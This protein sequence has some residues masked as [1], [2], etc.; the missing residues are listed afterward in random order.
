MF[1]RSCHAVKMFSPAANAW[2]R[3]APVAAARADT[4]FAA[5]GF[6]VCPIHA[7]PHAKIFDAA[8]FSFHIAFRRRY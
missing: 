2:R 8:Y 1:L 4:L 6:S 5:A 3:E 7:A